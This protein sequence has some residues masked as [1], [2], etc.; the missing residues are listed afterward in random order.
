MMFVSSTS[1]NLGKDYNET[2]YQITSLE[3]GEFV[4]KLSLTKNFVTEFILINS[5]DSQDDRVI[6]FEM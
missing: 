2:D 4:F 3:R 1:T 5:K 6:C